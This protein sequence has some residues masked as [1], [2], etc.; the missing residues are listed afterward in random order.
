MKLVVITAVLEFEKDIKK[1]LK[2][3]DVKTYSYKKVTG[4]RD[5][6][7]DALDTNWFATEMNENDSVLFY[8]FIREEK[9]EQVFGQIKQFNERTESLSRI[10]IAIINIEKSN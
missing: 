9:A 7:K 10:H 5:S 2:S 8:V 4:Y 6:T 1:I 3:A